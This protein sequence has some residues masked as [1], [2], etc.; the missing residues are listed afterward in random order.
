M[1]KN[2]LTRWLL[3]ELANSCSAVIVLDEETYREAMSNW[4]S[5]E[6]ITVIPNGIVLERIPSIQEV[7]N[8]PEEGVILYLGRIAPQKQLVSLIRAYSIFK[9]ECHKNKDIVLPRLALVGSG[10]ID[11]L[12]EIIVQLGLKEEVCLYGQSLHPERFLSNAICLINPSES[13]GLPNAVL[14]ACALGVPVILSDIPVHRKIAKD[15]EMENFLFP[16]GDVKALSEKLV[17]F[18]TLARDEIV[19]KRIQCAQY[20]KKFSNET[21]NEAYIDLYRRILYENKTGHN[22]GK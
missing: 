11:S 14:E 4:V 16:V 21:R 7:Q 15:I 2:W 13:E 5:K 6:K 17:K 9:A 10:E 12:K 22:M 19:T 1:S 20:S 3:P 18:L 8:I